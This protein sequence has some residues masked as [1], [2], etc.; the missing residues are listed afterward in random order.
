M[1]GI[2]GSSPISFLGLS[3][4]VKMQLFIGITKFIYTYLS[5]IKDLVSRSTRALA[6]LFVGI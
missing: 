2:A 5:A 3:Y 1:C 4:K 6:N